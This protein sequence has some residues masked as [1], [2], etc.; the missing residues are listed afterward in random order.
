MMLQ[1]DFTGTV[2]PGILSRSS[3][4]LL[5]STSFRTS[6]E[7][8]ATWTLVEPDRPATIRYPPWLNTKHPVKHSEPKI[9]APA[10]R[11][12][13]LQIIRASYQ[14]PKPGSALLWQLSE[15]QVRPAV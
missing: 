7:S 2:N 8:Y 11:D 9:A 12:T 6:G 5:S 10:M 1:Y 4:G 15:P 14:P 13:L 3:R